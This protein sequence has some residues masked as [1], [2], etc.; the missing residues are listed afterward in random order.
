MSG[1]QA[2]DTAKI[3]SHNTQA[4]LDGLS[5]D[6]TDI[7]EVSHLILMEPLLSAKLLFICNSPFFGYPRDVKNIGEAIV[8]LGATKLKN[9][10]Y[11]AILVH[12]NS[13]PMFQKYLQ[14][15]LLTAL[16]CQEISRHIGRD[17]NTAYVVGLFH[18]LPVI[19][20]YEHGIERILSTKIINKATQIILKKMNLPAS[21]TQSIIGL[22]SNEVSGEY[23]SLLR[24]AYNLSIIMQGK[25]Q[26]AFHHILDIETD[27]ATIGVTPAE[28]ANLIP[29]VD[30]KKN[31]LFDF[32]K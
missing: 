20:N 27:F 5:V 29:N 24:I 26:A 28:A 16:N 17:E 13:D 14:H 23:T 18:L 2:L 10:I 30:E 32:M 25:H 7:D 3:I 6:K 22:Y 8:L 21:I 15:S 19:V 9:L 12:D 11:T 1:L 4:I 31:A